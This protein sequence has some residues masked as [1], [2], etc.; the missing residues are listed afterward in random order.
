MRARVNLRGSSSCRWS[1]HCVQESRR[2]RS[3][4]A[5]E[6]W[7]RASFREFI[8][9]RRHYEVVSVQ[10]TDLVCPPGDRYLAPLG[11]Q[12]RVVPLLLGLLAYSVGESHCLGKVTEPELTLQIFDAFPL[13]YL[14]LG[15]LRAQLR[16]FGF[17]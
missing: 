4:P 3:S 14:P 12:R 8:R 13:H 11:Q 7:A 9:F 1:A 15:D 17:S 10:T 5:L 16:N 2:G 6:I